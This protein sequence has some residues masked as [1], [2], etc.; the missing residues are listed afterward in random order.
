MRLENIT[1][2]ILVALALVAVLFG[3]AAM[4]SAEAQYYGSQ[5]MQPGTGAYVSG[6]Y[7]GS[8]YGQCPAGYYYDS[9]ARQCVP[10]QQQY[11]YGG[12]QSC[13]AGYFFD[14]YRGQ[15]VPYMTAQGYG[16]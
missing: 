7:G 8:M 9:Y 12:P 2:K 5:Y 13:P 15:C 4:T 11:P 6:Q 3:P 10:A 1:R 14:Q 16:Y